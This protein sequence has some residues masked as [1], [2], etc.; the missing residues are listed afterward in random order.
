MFSSSEPNRLFH[1][2][3]LPAA[4]DSP[5]E[6]PN[7]NRD[8]LTICSNGACKI[9]STTFKILMDK[10]KGPLYAK[11]CIKCSCPI[12]PKTICLLPVFYCK[13]VKHPSEEST[14][15]CNN[16]ICGGCYIPM[17]DKRQRTQRNFSGYNG[18]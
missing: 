10:K 12:T 11:T 4:D 18:T 16:I 7:D 1:L 14:P 9:T 17:S 5:R 8:R 3:Q 15:I 6:R 2:S 13:L